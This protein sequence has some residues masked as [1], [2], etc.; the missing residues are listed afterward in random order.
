MSMSVRPRIGRA[1]GLILSVFTSVAVLAGATPGYAVS[2]TNPNPAVFGDDLEDSGV[3]TPSPTGVLT[4]EIFDLAGAL[5]V[6]STFGFFLE[7]NP[8]ELIPIF[9]PSDQDPDP[10]GPG[11]VPQVAAVDFSLGLVFDLDD[12]SSVQ[13]SFSGTGDIGFFLDPVPDDPGIPTLFTVPSLNPLGVDVAG[14]FPVLGAPEDD[15]LITFAVQEEGS[16]NVLPLAFELVGGITPVPQPVPEPRILL[17]LG[18]ML[19]ACLA[20][21]VAKESLRVVRAKRDGVTNARELP[22]R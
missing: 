5:G 10:G 6:G 7:G 1:K 8:S 2:F 4:V 12:A 14:T 20:Y 3:F 16:S 18:S 17:L 21:S 11:S 22:A 13:S 15:F 9:D 19:A